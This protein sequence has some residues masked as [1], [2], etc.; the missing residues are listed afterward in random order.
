MELNELKKNM[1]VLENLLSMTNTEVK[2]D[3]ARSETAQ[4][5]LIKT[6]R[7]ALCNCG[8][9]SIIPFVWIMSSSD[10]VSIPFYLKIYLMVFLLSGMI[11][12]LFLMNKTK[13]IDIP[14]MLPIQLFSASL[15]LRIYNLSGEIFFAIALA[16]FFSLFLPNF[17]ENKRVIFWLIIVFLTIGVI[18][19]LTYYV[20][21]QIRLFRE[22]ESLK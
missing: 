12:Y 6:Y 11:W 3:K 15:K 19:T 16:V 10:I 22:M 7:R 1:S 8:L 18:F 17:Y 5:K 13:R 4:M 9:A 21:K 20:P 14:T 2:I